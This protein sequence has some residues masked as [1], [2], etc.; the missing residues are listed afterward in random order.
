MAVLTPALHQRFHIGGQGT[1]EVELLSAPG[2]AKS[3]GFSVQG[4]AG[5][6]FETIFHKLAVLGEGGALEDF[7]ATVFLIHEE[8]VAQVFHVNS[9]LVGASGFQPALHEGHVAQALQNP[10]MRDRMFALAAVL[11]DL[12]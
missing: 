7:I 12:K 1:V 5:A 6:E 10:V 2:M 11:I 4:L 8:G 9:D 3:Q